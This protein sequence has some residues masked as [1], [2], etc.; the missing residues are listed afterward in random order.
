MTTT[1]ESDTFPLH[2]RRDRHGWLATT[3]GIL[4]DEQAKRISFQA[5]PEQV[6]LGEFIK[7]V[8]AGGTRIGHISGATYHER[9]FGPAYVVCTIELR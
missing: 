1:P 7:V 9:T 5:T 8:D 3:P 4:T 6:T 2:V